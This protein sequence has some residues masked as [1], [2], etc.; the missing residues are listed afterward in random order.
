M[1][2]RALLCLSLLLALTLLAA[3][4]LAAGAP[5]ARPTEA[6]EIARVLSRLWTGIVERLTFLK[7][8]ADTASPEGGTGSQNLDRGAELDPMG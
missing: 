3:P 2:R 8:A 4:A 7:T 5:K 6:P 1:A